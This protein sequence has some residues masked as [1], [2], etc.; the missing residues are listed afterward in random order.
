MKALS[1]KQPWAN[2]IASGQ[3][4]IETRLWATDFRG[5]LLI[6]SSKTPKIEPAG[7]ALAIA[8]L[9]EC[10]QM[11][12]EDQA[13]ARCELYRSAFAWVLADIRRVSPWPVRGQLGLYEVQ[14]PADF[15]VRR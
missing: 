11:T 3:K 2:L 8:R 13:A 1:V 7:Y 9:V 10:R 12:L 15:A 5:E 14:L 4:T 6:V